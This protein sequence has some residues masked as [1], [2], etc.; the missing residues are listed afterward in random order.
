MKAHSAMLGN[1]A[2]FSGLVN[3][4]TLGLSSHRLAGGH[5]LTGTGEMDPR[6]KIQLCCVSWSIR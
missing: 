4:E 3:M 6:S 1:V 2:A 5:R